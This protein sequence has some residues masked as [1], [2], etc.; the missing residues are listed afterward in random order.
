[1]QSPRGEMSGEQRQPAWNGGP[2][3]V[4][5]PWV[6]G[7]RSSGVW[8]CTVKGWQR[9]SKAKYGSETDSGEVE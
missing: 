5:A 3:R 8:Y 1:V 9:P 6:L 4:I 7:E 2:Q